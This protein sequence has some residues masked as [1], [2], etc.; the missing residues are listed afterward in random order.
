MKIYHFSDTHTFHGLLTIPENIDIM[1]F[2]GDA[3]N[4][5]DP[6]LNK[7]ELENFITWYSTIPVKYKIFVAG[8]HDTSIEKNLIKKSDFES[9]GI[10]YLENDYIEIEGL[11]IWGSP[12][13][14]T[15]GDGWAFNKNR[16]KLHDVWKHIPDD[17]D[18]I[19]VHG[20]PKGILDSS[21]N[22]KNEMEFCG[23]ESLR[24]RIHQIKPKL[25]LF[26]HIHN[27][28]DI[29]NSGTRTIPFLDTIFSNGTV[30]TDGKFGRVSSDGNIF[31]I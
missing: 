28:E 26:G 21:Y 7:I 11:K 19:V 12:I 15:F 14:P 9:N 10:I 5:R 24:K 17:T 30:V 20:P 1:I 3:S 13:T 18:I 6:Y 22:R 4:P 8:N 25:V 16:S 27:C 2:S 23:C 31:D 29:I